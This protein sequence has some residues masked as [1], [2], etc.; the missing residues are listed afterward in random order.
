GRA[1]A[2]G[3]AAD[4]SANDGGG[5][6]AGG[7]AEFYGEVNPVWR[8]G[9]KHINELILANKQ[10][11]DPAT[12]NIVSAV[13]AAKVS[14]LLS[15]LVAVLAAAACGLLLMR[16]IT[17]P[18]QLIVRLL[19]VTRTGDLSTRLNLSRKDEINPVDTGLNDMGTRPTALAA[20]AQRTS[21]PD[22]THG[23]A[24]TASHRAPQAPPP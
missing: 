1:A 19:D 6:S 12:A 24:T 16:S 4:V 5:D 18:M 22:T 10:R 14:M 13:L 8:T 2:E 3:R 9:R 11:A 23:P 17:A 7:R 21:R 15:L 20:L